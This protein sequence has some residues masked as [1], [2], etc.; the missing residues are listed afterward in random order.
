MQPL[1]SVKV[2]VSARVS[3]NA[4]TPLVQLARSQGMKPG[5][6]LAHVAEWISK[7]PGEKYHAAA[8]EFQR[9]ASRR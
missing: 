3:R 2:K 7:C 4:M 6:F 1:A 8:A 5:P 9:E